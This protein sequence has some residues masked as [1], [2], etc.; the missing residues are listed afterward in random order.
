MWDRTTQLQPKAEHKSVRV[1]LRHHLHICNHI[2]CDAEAALARLN[3]GLRHSLKTAQKASSQQG[4]DKDISPMGFHPQESLSGSRETSSTHCLLGKP[5][6]EPERL[7]SNLTWKIVR[8]RFYQLLQQKTDGSG[9]C[10]RMMKSEAKIQGRACLAKFSHSAL[11]LLISDENFH[12]FLE[13]HLQLASPYAQV[14]ETFSYSFK[15]KPWKKLCMLPGSFFL[16][17]CVLQGSVQAFLLSFFA[18][19]LLCF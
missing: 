6:S 3:L 9:V 12:L 17:F 19:R 2:F 5:V 4:W 11:S 16:V 14:S 1:D 10:D 7:V 8:Y 13:Q 15:L 18:M